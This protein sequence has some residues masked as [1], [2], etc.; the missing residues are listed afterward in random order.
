MSPISRCSPS[1]STQVEARGLRDELDR[2]VVVR[3]PEPAG[4]DAQVGAQTL[5]ER[6]G[7]LVL[8]VAD[9]DD[10]RGLDPQ[11]QEL[12]CDE[13][14]VQVVAVAAHELAA[15]HD[16]D[17]ARTDQTPGRIP[18]AVTTSVLT[19]PPGSNRV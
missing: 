16:D 8:A 3:R 15:G 12:P 5:G 1:S 9:D 14:A 13:G 17:S 6:V 4:D 7:Q 2:A 19:P 10:A 11:L 18:C